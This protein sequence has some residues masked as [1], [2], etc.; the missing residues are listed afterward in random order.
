MAATLI[1][2]AQRYIGTA[3][4]RAGLTTTNVKA[5]ATFYE[6]DTKLTYIWDS[7]AFQLAPAISATMDDLTILGSLIFTPSTAQVI[8]AV[9]DT[10]LA[11]ASLIELNPDADY[12]LTST[13]T[14]PDGTEGQWLYITMD[15]GE[16]NTITIQ[17]QGTL[18]GSNILLMN[19]APSRTIV[20]GDTLALRFDGADWQEIGT[21]KTREIYL[22][23]M[24]VAYPDGGDNAGTLTYQHD[25]TNHRNFWRWSSGQANQDIDMVWSFRLPP[26]FASFVGFSIDVRSNS[27][28][29]HVLTASLFDGSGSVDAGINGASIIPTA[30]NTWE[31]KTD[32]PTASYSAG[33]RPHLHVH[34]DIDTAS[35][36]IDVARIYFTYLATT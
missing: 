36:T 2:E 9:G 8:D 25:N 14:I 15:P 13:P 11:N 24:P 32:T 3:A 22:D 6:T 1:K 26:D 18:G 19:S 7:V 21:R 27:F 28:A 29:G 5:G 34:G 10:I 33:D 35:D 17:D 4:E 30:D 16:A 20:A 23:V 12:I 31:S